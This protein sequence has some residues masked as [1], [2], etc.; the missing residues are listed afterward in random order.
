MNPAL[1]AGGLVTNH[2]RPKLKELQ[3]P[4]MGPAYATLVAILRQG[5]SNWGGIIGTIIAFFGSRRMFPGEND[6]PALLQTILEL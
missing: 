2:P 6:M 3:L 1:W 5:Y 4:G